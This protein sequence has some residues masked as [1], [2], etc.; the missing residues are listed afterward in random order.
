MD[1]WQLLPND[2]VIPEQLVGVVA[3]AENSAGCDD[4]NANGHQ[5]RPMRSI[6]RTGRSCQDG[7]EAD[8]SQTP[9]ST[10]PSSPGRRQGLDAMVQA[11]T[12]QAMR[13]SA[14]VIRQAMTA[15]A[16][17]NTRFMR[18]GIPPTLIAVVRNTTP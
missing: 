6:P 16:R 9:K 10:Y 4:K 14:S 13:P 17:L 2:A 12:A 8:K 11:N 7:E 15:P 18:S 1:Q 3:S 5:H